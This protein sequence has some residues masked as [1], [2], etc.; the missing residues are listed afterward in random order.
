MAIRSHANE[1]WIKECT[2]DVLVSTG[3]L[4]DECQ[5]AI[6]LFHSRQ[7]RHIS[8]QV[9]RTY[10][11]CSSR[12]E[13]IKLLPD[14]GVTLN[15]KKCEFSPESHPLPLSWSSPWAPQGS[16]KNNWQQRIFW[17]LASKTKLHLCLE[18]GNIFPSPVPRFAP[19]AACWMRSLGKVN[20]RRMTD[21]PS[22]K[23]PC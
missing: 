10:A 5:A 22:M 2:L 9:K 7:H 15:L 14:E 21:N 6:G 19:V 13:V 3:R 17:P 16:E 20:C 8:T 23:I 1:L 4:I 12:V 18:L 11:M